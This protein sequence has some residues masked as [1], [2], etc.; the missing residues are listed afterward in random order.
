MEPAFI[1]S[2]NGLFSFLESQ[3]GQALVAIGGIGFLVYVKGVVK[4]TS[5]PAFSRDDWAVGLDLLVLSVVTLLSGAIA[6]FA[7]EKRAHGTRQI[8]VARDIELNA[9]ASA[10]RCCSLVIFYAGLD[11]TPG[12]VY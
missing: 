3:T 8:Q 11:S 1:V 12:L 7:T 9:L 6:A 10:R 4:P 2:R 5:K